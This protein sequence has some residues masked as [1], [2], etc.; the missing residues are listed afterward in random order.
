MVV[1]WAATSHLRTGMVFNAIEMARWFP[2]HHR[3]DLRCHSEVG[4]QC[5]SIRHGVRLAEI[6]ATPASGSV[7]DSYDYVL[8]ETVKRYDT[9]ELGRGPARP[10]LWKTV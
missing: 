5:A 3:E 8:A 10:R 9:T 1:G 2:D 6:G 7:G 4:S